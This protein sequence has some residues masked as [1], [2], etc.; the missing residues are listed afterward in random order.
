MP[1][2]V[3]CSHKLKKFCFS[4]NVTIK[5]IPAPPLGQE[6][7]EVMTVNI[8]PVKETISIGT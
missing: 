2:Q 4:N 7:V 5:S 6:R 1:I 3:K 8:L